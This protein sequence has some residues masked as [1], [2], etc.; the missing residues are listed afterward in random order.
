MPDP[1]LGNGMGT[2]LLVKCQGWIMNGIMVVDEGRVFVWN[3][4]I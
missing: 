2:P 1:D 4:L 3:I